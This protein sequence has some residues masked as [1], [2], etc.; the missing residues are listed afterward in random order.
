MSSRESLVA[1]HLQHLAAFLGHSY[2]LF[3]VS[4]EHAPEQ[5]WAEIDISNCNEAEVKLSAR[6]WQAPSHIQNQVLLHELLHISF[7]KKHELF[8]DAMDSVLDWLSATDR[9]KARAMLDIFLKGAERVEEV[10]VNRLAIILAKF[11]P[12]FNID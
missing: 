8:L 10:E 2:W 6:F 12:P 11:A 4:A 3:Y 1:D 5:A 9:K 7:H